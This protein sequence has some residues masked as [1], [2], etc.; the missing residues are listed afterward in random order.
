MASSRWAYRVAAGRLYSIAQAIGVEI[1]YF[2][3]GLQIASGF[4]PPASRRMLLD[5]ACNFLNISDPRH[6]E[7]VATLAQALAESKD[8]GQQ[9]A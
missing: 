1:G 5:L 9:V 7:A 4:V 3:E 6:Q 8:G 2:F